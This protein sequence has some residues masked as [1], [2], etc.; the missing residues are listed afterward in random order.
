MTAHSVRLVDLPAHQLLAIRPLLREWLESPHL[1]TQHNSLI[2][3]TFDLRR[4]RS[5][6]AINRYVSSKRI[7]THVNVDG[8]AEA[9]GDRKGNHGNV[10]R[11][12]DHGETHT[13]PATARAVARLW[14]R[15]IS[16][17]Q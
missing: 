6:R 10:A 3:L 11:D 7:R 12:I 2:T 9:A 16:V 1:Y 17:K 4:C 5:R 14:Y 15:A 8:G 13:P